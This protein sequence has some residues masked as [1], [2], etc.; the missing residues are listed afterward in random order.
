MDLYTNAHMSAELQQIQAAIG[1]LE[2]Q[3]SLL[4]DALV[5]AALAPLR[6]KLAALMA[7]RGAVAAPAAESAQTLKQVT[8]L[9]LDVVGSTTLSQHLDPEDIHAVMDGALARFTTIVTARRGRVLQ[10]AGDSMLAVFGADE[11]REDDAEH[12]VHAGLD[13]LAEGVRLGEEV[14]RAHGHTG[15]NV[16]VGLHTGGVLLGGGVDAEGTIRGI[17]VNVTARMEQTA[18]TGTMRISHDTYRHVRGVFDVEPQ[19]PITV[20]GV[21]EPIQSYLVLRA[22]P[23]AFRITTRGIE[24]V[25]TRMV[26]RDA[27]LEQLQEAFKRVFARR[28][29]LAVNVVADT[30]VGKSRL[31]YEFETW[32]ESQREGFYLFQGRANPQTQTQPYG[33]L[34]DMLAWRLQIADGDSMQ[35]ARQK[36]EQGIAPLFEADDGPDLALAH[37]HL[38]GHLIGLDF[39]DSKY[40][41]GIIDDARQIRNR[42]FHTAAQMLRRVSAQNDAPVV[43]QLEDLHWADDGSLDFLNYLAQVNRD[44]PILVLG[45]TRP[46]LFERRPDW[47]NI[48]DVYQ[49]IDLSPLDKTASRMLANELL[50][51]L[52]EIPASLREMVTSGAEG[53]PFYMEE[54]VKML[55]DEKAI[56]TSGERWVLNPERLQATRVP[57]TLTGVLQARLDSLQPTEKLA[58]QQASVIGF[59]FWDQALAAIDARALDSL[60]VLVQRDFNV[61]RQDAALDGVREYAFKHQILHQVTYDTLLKRTRRGFHAAAAAWL[62]GLTGAR[63]GD[64]LG[65]TAEHFDKAGDAAQAS[66]YFTRAAEHAK[67]RFAHDAALGYVERALATIDAQTDSEANQMLRWR[68]L[69]VRERTLDLQGRRVEQR[70]DIDTLQKVADTLNDDRRRAELCGRRSHLAMRTGDYTTM[71]REARQAMTLAAQAGD[72]ELKLNAQRLLAMGLGLRGDAAAGRALAQ[73]GLTEARSRALRRAEALFLNALSVIASW[74]DDVVCSLEMDQQ[75]LLIRRELGDQGSEAN[76]LGNLGLWWLSLGDRAQARRHLED[77]L[78]LH[79][80]VG[81]R[82][83]EPAVLAN[84]SALA[85]WQGDDALSLTHARSALDIAVAV[86]AP[87]LE[88]E[89]L[90]RLGDAELALG[91]NAAAAAAFE[92][93]ER[94]AQTIS[95]PKLFDALAGRARVSLAQGD[96]AQAQQHV[97]AILA[98]QAAGRSL[99]GAD[100]RSMLLASYQVLA[101]VGDARARELLERAHSE[102]Q[103]RAATIEN[104]ALRY[105]FLNGIPTHHDIAMA[106]ARQQGARQATA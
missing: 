86:Q 76:A 15:F 88:T 14:A 95:N 3:R 8:I 32:A 46:T 75:N 79:R 61:P 57:Q 70:A 35:T 49:R 50:K 55:V 11:A 77:A 78:K 38:L 71:E 101:Q 37:A 18:P 22:K 89:A 45:L 2:S 17:A 94:V 56:D 80:S 40:V 16:R 60:G 63:A 64:F 104:A 52:P 100:T 5:E 90:C 102:L 47:G 58:L 44:V 33:L 25:E 43:M 85:L 54:L 1:G 4:G 62:A 51:K 29:L 81:N 39:S 92:R 27:E 42:G 96:Q 105:S 28:Q 99:E 74:Q 84:L 20:K 30:G 10:Y 91:R 106:W 67:R 65:I 98:L 66:E 87:D 21:D 83:L 6:A 69:D 97:E 93:A 24:G 103:Q 36:L 53:N 19:P 73:E 41:K 48:E 9:F 34:R 59:V 13:L 12:A 23:R 68:L 72:H 7:E 82:A 31:L 26:G